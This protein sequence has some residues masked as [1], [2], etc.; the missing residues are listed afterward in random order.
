MRDTAKTIEF[1]FSF[2]YPKDGKY[3][4]AK[5]ITVCEPGFDNRDVFRRMGGFIA[6]AQ[7][8]LFKTFAGMNREQIAD[9]VDSDGETAEQTEGDLDPLMMLRM[10]LSVDEYDAFLKYVEKVLTGNKMLAYVGTDPDN[11]TP[12]TEEVWRNIAAQGGLGEMERVLAV[13]ICFFT[14]T[15]P[16]QAGSTKGNGAEKRPS[17]PAR[18]AA[19][20]RSKVH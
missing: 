9:K 8:G 4:S 15:P 14:D 17:S 5:A 20:S 12:V 19:V 3:E 1:D 13:F 7:K 6:N 16:V 11:R 18:P 10:G 2:D